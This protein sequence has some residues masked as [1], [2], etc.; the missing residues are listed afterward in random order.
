MAARPAQR[1]R[2]IA[3]AIEEEQR[4]LA[5]RET[6][7]QARHGGRGNESALRRRVASQIDRVDHGREP[8][9]G[10][11]GQRQRRVAAAVGIGHRLQRRRR[12]DENCWNVAQ[13][14]A[15]HRHVAR[16]IGDAVLLL[17]GRI[18]LLVDDDEAELAKGQEQ[19]GTG[20]DHHTCFALENRP[21]GPPALEPAEVGVPF[22]RRRAEARTK[23]R[24]PLCAQRDLRQQHQNLQLVGE[25]RSDRF[26]VDLRFAGPGHAV[27]ETD[28]ETLRDARAQGRRHLGLS[29]RQRKARPAPVGRRLAV[30]LHRF[31]EKRARRDE[32]AHH[33]LAAG[34][35]ASE[36]SER[37]GGPW[38]SAANTRVRAAVGLM[39]GA[40]VG[41]T[42]RPPR[43]G[44]RQRL[45]YTHYHPQHRARRMNGVA[46]HPIDK[47]ARDFG[48]RRSGQEPAERLE[49]RILHLAGAGSPDDSRE[50]PAAE[51]R[52][53]KVAR[54]RR[55]IGRNPV[56]VGSSERQRQQN[57][58]PLAA[59]KRR[60]V[61]PPP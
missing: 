13:P 11:V 22:A 20:T 7:R 26:E 56:I 47:L 10:T 12:R 38:A 25:R 24:A 42:Q 21:P 9:A 57:A 35:L 46:R 6:S 36:F 40:M 41:F 32:A 3:A 2:R 53:D 50:H 55:K 28:G 54:G 37:A 27:D 17:E 16:V 59:S 60:P 18:V 14:R 5:G 4:L 1:Q 44:R 8:A 51:R 61:S 43:R 29:G 45:G 19:S 23:A 52:L 49:L 33:G 39:S 48:Q 31:G 30:R 58:D 34:R 15:H